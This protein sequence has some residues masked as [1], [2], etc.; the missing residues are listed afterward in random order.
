MRSGCCWSWSRYCRHAL[1]ASDPSP[2]PPFAPPRPAPPAA[3]MAA[4]LQPHCLNPFDRSA[5][6]GTYL[7]SSDNRALRTR[8]LYARS[9][10]FGGGGGRIP[11]CLGSARGENRVGSDSGI[12]RRRAGGCRTAAVVPCRPDDARG[13]RRV[14][15]RELTL[16]LRQPDAG[17]CRFY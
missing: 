11:R 5:H 1:Y 17:S 12:V 2:F 14:G 13:R 10:L 7:L 8:A 6:L 4:G 3:A 9:I 15:Q 16:G